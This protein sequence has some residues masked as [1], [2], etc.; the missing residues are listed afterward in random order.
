[1]CRACDNLKGKSGN[2]VYKMVEQAYRKKLEN[3]PRFDLYTKFAWKTILV[4]YLLIFSFIYFYLWDV[5]VKC[6]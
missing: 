2:D 1:M 3:D 6:L 4:I 5:I